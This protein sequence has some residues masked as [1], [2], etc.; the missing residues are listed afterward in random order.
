MTQTFLLLAAFLILAATQLAS[1]TP[2]SVE[3]VEAPP[4]SSAQSSFP[5]IVD[6]VF[7]GNRVT[8]PQTMLQEMKVA[9]GDGCDPEKIEESRQAIMDLNLFKSVVAKEKPVAGGVIL[10]VTVEEKFFIL[11]LP[12]LG[13][14]NDGDIWGGAYIKWYNMFGMNYT[15]KL[16]GKVKNFKDGDMESKKFIE[17]EYTMPRLYSGPWELYLFGDYSRDSVYAYDEERSR[18]EQSTWYGGF[19]MSRWLYLEGPSRGW[20]IRGGATYTDKK[21]ELEEGTPGLYED[22][23][24]PQLSLGG[25]FK[26]IHD[27]LFSRTGKEFG[28]LFEFGHSPV[29]AEGLFTTHY[30]YYRS[31]HWL[32]GNRHHNL[33][34]QF[35]AAFA[36]DSRYQ[37][38]RYKLG[39]SKTL[40]GYERDSVAGN[41]YLLA[42]IEYLHP[43]FG[44]PPLR[45]VVFADL[46]NSWKNIDDI[47]PSDLKGSVGF[48]VRAKVKY[49]VKL[50][51]VLEWAFTANGENKVYA[52]TTV[53]F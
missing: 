25:G 21:N 41:A 15:F 51:L 53:P 3:T 52:G 13:Y 7:V 4:H 49:F 39:S 29:D 1:A 30:F 35:Q 27:H 45:G 18:Y 34:F 31:Y 38:Y 6:I 44:N 12:T 23:S 22:G 42:N 46:G 40:R 43:L 33:N 32:F 37:E 16:K 19:S 28:Y 20:F 8:R 50:D 5:V 47:D 9:K 26:A 48:G 14:S 24:L 2:I 36:S 17:F 10:E 11:P